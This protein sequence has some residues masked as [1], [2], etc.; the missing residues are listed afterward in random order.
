VI[1]VPFLLGPD[2]TG[3]VAALGVD[4]GERFTEAHLELLERVSEPFRCLFRRHHG[5]EGALGEE[6]RLRYTSTLTGCQRVELADQFIDGGLVSTIGGA[7][8]QRYQVFPLEDLG[9]KQIRAAIADPFDWQSLDAFEAV[10][11]HRITDRRLAP[12]QEI[13]EAL[14]AYL[15]AISK[16][17][18]AD[19][20]SPPD[21]LALLAADLKPALEPNAQALDSEQISEDSAPVVR[22]ASQLIREAHAV[23]ASDVHVEA[24]E[25]KLMVRFRVDGV[26][27]DRLILPAQ[28]A[29]PLVARLKVMSNLD[30]AEHRLPQDGRLQFAHFEPD[31][32]L[33]L[34]V[35]VLPMLHGECVVMR[36][37]DRTSTQLPLEKLGFSAHNLGLY[38]DVIA[39]PFGMILHC[40]PTGSGK[41][42]SL[43]AAINEINDPQW[44]IVTAEDP[45]EYTLDGI[46]QLQIHKRIGLTFAAALRC[47]LRHDPDVILVGEIR[48]SETAQ[49]ATEAALTGHLLLSTLH[50]ND[51]A[52]SVSRL[53]RLGIEPFLVASALVAV[54]AQRLVRRVCKCRHTREPDGQALSLLRRARDGRPPSLIPVP[55]GCDCCHHSGYH[56]RAGIHELMIV[57]QRIRQH[58]GDQVSAEV[59]KLAARKQGMRTLFEDAMAKVNAGVTSLDE[60]LRVARPDELH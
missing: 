38:R 39:S 45:I 53:G 5:L 41:S 9:D 51:A 22:L 23:G 4:G 59:L 26:C 46:N 3:L 10:S 28:V 49:I 21:P 24:R 57:G 36:L 30:I 1:A 12:A 44:K 20:D 58:I 35:S 7:T 43:F 13:R 2:H 32:D 48:D 54:C 52:T 29:R 15:E 40:G 19:A 33:D 50:T 56:G 16:A 25:D 27:R 47:F 34:R 55:L 18:Q 11:G 60:A 17:A 8:L 14:E 6:E 37:L 31:L 42:T